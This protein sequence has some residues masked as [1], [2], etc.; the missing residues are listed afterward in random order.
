MKVAVVVAYRVP[1]DEMFPGYSGKVPPGYVLIVKVLSFK[2][3]RADNV[4]F[5]LVKVPE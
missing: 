4:V 1:H 3:D 5:V 2:Y